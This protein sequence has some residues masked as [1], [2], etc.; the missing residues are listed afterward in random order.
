ML[1]DQDIEKLTE[2]L[3]TKADIKNIEEDIAEIRGLINGQTLTINTLFKS[4]AD[5]R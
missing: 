4:I 3:A 2:V 1:T 5:L